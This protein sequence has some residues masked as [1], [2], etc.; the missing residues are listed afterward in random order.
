MYPTPLVVYTHTHKGKCFLY[1]SMH[2]FTF[3]QLGPGYTISLMC[4]PEEMINGNAK[5][6]FLSSLH[7][8]KSPRCSQLKRAPLNKK[9]PLL[10]NSYKMKYT[11][12]I[13]Y[14][15]LPTIGLVK[16]D[17]KTNVLQHVAVW[18]SL[19]FVRNISGHIHF[20]KLLFFLSE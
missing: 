12:D 19:F 8:F 2:V 6:N 9:L 17:I 20:R 4:H 16:F 7:Y 18:K 5:P 11:A 1:V 13:Y 3:Y 15:P 14:I 10:M